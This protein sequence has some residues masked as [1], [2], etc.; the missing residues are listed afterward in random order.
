MTNVAG[1]AHAMN[2]LTPS[3]PRITWI[4]RLLFM[5][6]RG[7]PERLSGLLGLSPI[8]F[9]R[10]VVIKPEEWPD[11]GQGKQSLKNDYMLSC[12]NFNGT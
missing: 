9:A 12:S 8:H 2:A 7:V 5:A 1:N 10:W 4:K 11:L 6:A 3:K